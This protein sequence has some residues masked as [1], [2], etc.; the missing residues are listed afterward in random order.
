MDYKEQHRVNVA[1][2]KRW[3]ADAARDKHDLTAEGSRLWAQGKHVEASF[4]FEEA[5]NAA[6]WEGRRHRRLLEE[7]RKAGMR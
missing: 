4:D 5:R 7:E 6:S 2:E 3:I 1:K